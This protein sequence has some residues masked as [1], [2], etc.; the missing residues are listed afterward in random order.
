MAFLLA[1]VMMAIPPPSDVKTVAKGTLSGIERAR[2]A[3]VRTE[4]EWRALWKEHAPEQPPPPVDFTGRTVLAIFLG[5]RNT[6]GFDVEITRIERDGN[7]VSVRY[8]ET[9]PAPDGM[10]AQIITAPFHIVSVPRFDGPATFST[11]AR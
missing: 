5:S 10:V 11:D 6:A 1:L 9:R 7:G 4:A 2:Q 8:R 3:V